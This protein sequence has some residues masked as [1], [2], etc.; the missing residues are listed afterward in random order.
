MQRDNL[1]VEFQTGRLG[2]YLNTLE[3]GKVV[4]SKVTNEDYKDKI[5]VGDVLISVGNV[6][7]EKKSIDDITKIISS[8][9]RPLAVEF[10]IRHRS[11][12][13]QRKPIQSNSK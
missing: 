7:V 8:S 2:M 11:N 10:D 13:N 6:N 9:G 5:L 3:D 1:Q 12:A 4:V